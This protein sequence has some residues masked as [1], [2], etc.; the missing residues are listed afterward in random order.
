MQTNP[1]PPDAEKPTEPSLLE[2]LAA[3]TGLFNPT[4]IWHEEE[5]LDTMDEQEAARAATEAEAPTPPS[6]QP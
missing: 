1:L 2:E 4:N 5:I 6:E 3:L